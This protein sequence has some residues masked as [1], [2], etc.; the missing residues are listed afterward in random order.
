MIFAVHFSRTKMRPFLGSRIYLPP[1]LL[2]PNRALPYPTSPD[3]PRLPRQNSRLKPRPDL[4]KPS[5]ARLPIP[6]KPYRTS[7]QLAVPELAVTAITLT[8]PSPTY[9][10]CPT[11]KPRQLVTC[12]TKPDLA[13]TRRDCQTRRTKPDP[14]QPNEP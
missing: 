4:N 3:L 2:L 8:R 6:T 13:E 1:L 10:P 12:Q 9:R 5:H 14:T 11:A 7:P